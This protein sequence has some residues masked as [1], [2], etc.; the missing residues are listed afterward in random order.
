M[1]KHSAS[2]AIDGRVDGE[3][4]RTTFENDPWWS[5][6]LQREKYIMAVTV[7]NCCEGAMENVEIRISNS[8]K[9]DKISNKICGLIPELQ[10]NQFVTLFCSSDAFGRYVNIKAPGN[11]RS[12]ALCE[13]KVYET[14]G[15]NVTFFF[16]DANDLMYMLSLGLV[17]F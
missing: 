11:D 9:N 17:I 14:L 4:S 7:T 1:S 3:C 12:L 2:H 16:T 5:V 13:V 10:D 15:K 8:L 6:D